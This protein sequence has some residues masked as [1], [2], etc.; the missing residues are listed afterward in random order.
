MFVTATPSNFVVTLAV[1][2]MARITSPGN[3]RDS[4]LGTHFSGLA[5]KLDLATY[6]KKDYMCHVSKNE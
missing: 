5:V 6:M 3:S 4:R 2:Q 1:V